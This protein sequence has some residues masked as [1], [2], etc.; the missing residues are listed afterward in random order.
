[1]WSSSS[2]SWQLFEAWWSK[3]RKKALCW[4]KT[5]GRHQLSCSRHPIVLMLTHVFSDVTGNMI[6]QEN[7]KQQLSSKLAQNMHQSV[8]N[9]TISK[10]LGK[11]INSLSLYFF[12]SPLTQM[13]AG[14]QVHVFAVGCSSLTKFHEMRI[15]KGR[16]CVVDR[17]CGGY[18][19]PLWTN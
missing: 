5:F 17:K 14:L 13:H 2:C 4:P 3:K 10:C 6:T 16:L 8:F 1:M 19:S 7:K 11:C 9:I 12:F 15:L 18:I